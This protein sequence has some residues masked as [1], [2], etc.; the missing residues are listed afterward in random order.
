[1]KFF[2]NEPSAPWW[3]K[4]AETASIFLFTGA[5]PIVSLIQ[6]IDPVW[7]DNLATVFLPLAVLLIKT[8]SIVMGDSAARPVNPEQKQELRQVESE[9]QQKWTDEKQ[10]NKPE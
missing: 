1:M 3:W 10:A 6:G 9:L 5:I 2:T 4:R 8:A 7:R